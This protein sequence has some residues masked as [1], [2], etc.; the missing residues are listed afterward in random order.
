M[1]DVFSELYY[2]FFNANRREAWQGDGL[3]DLGNFR[4][5]I[6][7]EHRRNEKSFLGKREITNEA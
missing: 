2:Y 4:N 5:F 6:F 1:Y 3:R 7:R